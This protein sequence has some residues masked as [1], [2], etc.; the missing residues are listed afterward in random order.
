MNY[1]TKDD[2]SKLLVGDTLTLED[3]SVHEAVND[4]V[5]FEC[6]GSC[7]LFIINE[8]IVKK[9]RCHLDNYHFKQIKP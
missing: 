1:T 2:L 6:V 4:I 9:S 3:G 7:S 8:C 5:E